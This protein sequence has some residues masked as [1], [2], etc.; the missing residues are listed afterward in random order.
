[1][2][3][4]VVSIIESVSNLECYTPFVMA[5]ILMNF[6]V[7]ADSNFNSLGEKKIAGEGKKIKKLCF[8]L[9]IK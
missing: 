8:F 3:S 5:K 9:F 7:F 2:L 4:I 6:L 1:M